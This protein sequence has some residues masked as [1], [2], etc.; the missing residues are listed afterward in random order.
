[1][2]S[3]VA[4]L[5]IDNGFGAY[6]RFALVAIVDIPAGV[7]MVADY[8]LAPWFV[9]QAPRKWTCP[10]VE[11]IDDVRTTDQR[12]MYFVYNC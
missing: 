6:Y 2:R 12:A 8:R 7:E 3:D 9:A 10:G 1:M 11:R 4:D 5:G